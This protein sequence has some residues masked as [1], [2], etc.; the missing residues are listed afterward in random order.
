[1]LAKTEN[2]TTVFVRQ[3]FLYN[4]KCP[5]NVNDVLVCGKIHNGDEVIA[6]NRQQR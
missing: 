6:M 4:N 1:M 3:R 5:L 2:W